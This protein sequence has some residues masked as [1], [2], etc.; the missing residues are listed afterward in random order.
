MSNVRAGNYTVMH[1]GDG[2]EELEQIRCDHLSQHDA[3][4]HK[5]CRRYEDFTTIGM[6]VHCARSAGYNSSLLHRLDTG[7]G[8]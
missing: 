1:S 2:D 6:Y 8:D 4:L 5:P 3:L 7:L